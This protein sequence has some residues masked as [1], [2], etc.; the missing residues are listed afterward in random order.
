[1][2]RTPPRP[3]FLTVLALLALVSVALGSARATPAA[4]S[5]A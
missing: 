2:S 3:A 5:G 1:M 4:P